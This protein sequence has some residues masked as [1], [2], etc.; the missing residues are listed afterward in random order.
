MTA[1]TSISAGGKIKVGVQA[2][3][4][5]TTGAITANGSGEG[6]GIILDSSASMTADTS[7]TAK[8]IDV[9]AGATVTATTGSITAT[10]GAITLAETHDGY[11][12]H[13]TAG[14]SIAAT[15][16][17]VG[18]GATVTATA[19]SITAT[20]GAIRLNS[21][22]LGSIDPYFVGSTMTAGDSIAATQ[23]DVG[24]K[25][26]M[27]AGDSITATQIDLRDGATVKATNGSIT[28]TNGDIMLHLDTDLYFGST[29]TADDSISAAGKIEVSKRSSMSAS[30]ITAGETITLGDSASMTARS[31]KAASIDNR[32]GTINIDGTGF[33][34][35][36][37]VIDVD[38]NDGGTLTPGHINITYS[39]WP[40]PALDLIQL[41]DGDVFI[42]DRTILYVNAAWAGD[43]VGTEE[44]FGNV[45]A[46]IGT[47]AF[48]AV[49]GA[50]GT[51]A[52]A[53]PIMVIGGEFTA[54]NAP[55][56]NG[57]E[58]FIQDGTFNT[59]V[60]GGEFVVADG[61]VK[62]TIGS[63]QAP[64][65]DVSLTLSGG[66]FNKIVFAGD[67]LDS[68]CGVV[69]YGN[70]NLTIE[71]GTYNNVVAGAEAYT[72]GDVGNSAELHGAV[73]L[74]IKGGTFQAPSNKD[75]IYGGCMATD[76]NVA[77]STAIYGTVTVRLDSTDGE[78]AAPHVVA[79]SYGTGNIYGSTTLEVTGSNKIT[80]TDLWGGCSSDIYTIGGDVVTY[81]KESDVE[82]AA[83]GDRLLSFTGFQGT[84]ECAKI[85]DF[86][87]AEFKNDSQVTL[88]K[89]TAEALIDM[90]FVSNWT[91][92]LD[93]KLIG[94]DFKND[95]AGDTFVYGSEGDI[96]S[97]SWGG[98]NVFE[99]VNELAL[100]G[101][102]KNENSGFSSVTL[103]GLD[104]GWISDE[105]AYVTTG[106]SDFNFK[107][108]MTETGMAVGIA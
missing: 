30:S 90:S 45:T 14:D 64:A 97:S 95:F 78:V 39:S 51:A 28:A 2:T 20:T 62:E 35:T 96:T 104:A 4:T 48:A 13:M 22:D 56:F 74:T 32:S 38:S 9:G 84:L 63:E 88:S 55:T 1:G 34:G 99:N 101:F 12:A 21:K 26:E 73:T 59:S 107:L 54:S 31:I 29:M 44:R 65:N 36:K 18:G 92:D 42:T 41:A 46:T 80:A 66:V 94:A 69:R 102:A 25:S 98:A 11:F 19:G 87:S 70:V 40:P 17:D 16:I 53:N 8:L 15:I 27:T 37:K 108:S 3:V 50:V 68:S 93:S 91:F 83:D 49:A 24:R 6:D 100:T 58:T 103:F 60:C 85:R 67:R 10:T 77:A 47:D 33:S 61:F 89:G 79:G 52:A 5:A 75:W 43:A 7:I 86:T 72:Y 76:K 106:G 81:V 57:I 23:I 105:N 82:E 71:G